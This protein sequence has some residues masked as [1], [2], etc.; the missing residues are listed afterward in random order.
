MKKILNVVSSLDS[1]GVET[2]LYN[3]YSNFKNNELIFDFAVYAKEEGMIEKK[4][5][6]RGA[7]IYHIT[8][9]K[10]SVFRNLYDL[11]LVVKNGNY[12]A[13]YS[14][15]NFYS[16]IALFYAKIFSVKTRIAHSHGIAPEKISFGKRIKNVINR[17]A[18]KLF[19]TNFFACSNEAGEYLYGKH[20]NEKNEKY[21][22]IKNA[23][24]IS[25][26]AYDEEIRKKYRKE[27]KIGDR[28]CLLHIGRFAP[29]KN[30][31]FL[32]DI[33]NQLDSNKFVLVCVGDGKELIRYMSE[34]KNDSI[35][36]TGK[37]SDIEAFYS[38]G[39]IFLLPSLHE[40]LGIV[41]IEAQVSGLRCIASTN[42]PNEAKLT[43]NVTFL[44]LEA[45]QWIE[46]I[47]N[48]TLYKR[49]CEVNII[50]DKGYNI[51]KESEKFEDMLCE[52]IKNK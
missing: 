7:K 48:Q 17:M 33:I 49:N 52:L 25:K 8:P 50:T 27:Y 34:Y 51:K 11:F 15:M 20:W 47:K 35:I 14:H 43:N 29:E 28:I 26:F 21:L 1:G 22:I 46:E 23:I 44:P 2:M 30:H 4:L 41:L 10:K 19:A 3:Y 6:E 16:W 42:V 9:R 37:R 39:D 12:D 38:M 31:K 32:M 5:I 40:G 36:F 13:V 24:D 45:E 18:I